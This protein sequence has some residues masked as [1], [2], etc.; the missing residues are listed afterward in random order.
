MN[1]RSANSLQKSEILGGFLKSLIFDG[2]LIGEKSAK[3][4]KIGSLGRP[5][6]KVRATLGKGR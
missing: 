1:F 5:K 2:F 3:N 4:L 6:A